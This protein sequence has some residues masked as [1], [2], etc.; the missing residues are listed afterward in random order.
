MLPKHECCFCEGLGFGWRP[1]R[2]GSQ[3]KDDLHLNKVSKCALYLHIGLFHRALPHIRS[4][5]RLVSRD[6]IYSYLNLE[7][8]M[9]RLLPQWSLVKR[10]LFEKV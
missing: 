9:Q 7:N 8:G 5:I 3:G 1:L 2:F 4:R 6:P 10:C